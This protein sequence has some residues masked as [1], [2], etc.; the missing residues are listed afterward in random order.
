MLK[1]TFLDVLGSLLQPGPDVPIF[2]HSYPENNLSFSLGVSEGCVDISKY[3]ERKKKLMQ[4][5][6]IIH[7][8]LERS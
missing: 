7:V 2:V 4:F 3:F 6:C 1:G 5:G 8:L